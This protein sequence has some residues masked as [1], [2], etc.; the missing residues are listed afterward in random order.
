M[1]EK[2]EITGER[3]QPGQATAPREQGPHP[4]TRPCWAPARPSFRN[5]APYISEWEPEPNT[6]IRLPTIRQYSGR[7][8]KK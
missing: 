4:A 8:T 3:A 2:T 5:T 7:S 6:L 1:S